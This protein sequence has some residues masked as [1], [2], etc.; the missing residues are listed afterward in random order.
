TFLKSCELFSLRLNHYRRSFGNKV[1]ITEL[2]FDPANLVSVLRKHLRKTRFRGLKIDQVAERQARGCL[3]D[4]DLSSA[5]RP[6]ISEIDLRDTRKTP[7]CCVV[8]CSTLTA[9]LIC[10]D[11][12]QRSCC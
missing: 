12:H 8:P 1:R 6:P 11:K 5:L 3:A 10:T 2:L 7:D 4:H 9:L